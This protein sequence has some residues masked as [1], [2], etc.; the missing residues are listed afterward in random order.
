MEAL[1]RLPRITRN[2]AHWAARLA[3]VNSLI[4]KSEWRRR[5][6]LILC[7]HGVSIDDE[8]LWS[9]LYVSPEHLDRRLRAV[10]KAGGAILPFREAVQRLYAG[11]LPDCATALTFDDGAFD[12]SSRAVPVLNAVGAHSTLYLTTWYSGR[13]MPVFDTMASYLLWKGA[14]QTI[15]LPGTGDRVT[16][17]AGSGS[18]ERT[19][20]HTRLLDFAESAR[21]SGDEKQALLVELSRTVKV[22][23]D[24]LMELRMLQIMRPDEVAQLD[25]TMVDVELH[26][27]RHRTPRSQEGLA[28]EIGDNQQ[29]IADFTGDPTPRRHFCYP[30][31][32]FIADYGP[33][34]KS[35]GVETATTCDPGLATADTDPYFLPRIFDTEGLTDEMFLAWVTGAGVVTSPGQIFPRSR[36]R[37]R[38]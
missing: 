33:W 2:A 30:S 25:R 38:N 18:S 16:I 24:R 15:R 8:H 6:L 34:L 35:L 22:D 13:N 12:F 7:Y 23:F 17:P 14:G 11:E 27:H 5:R 20:L 10:R 21:L 28:V 32:D 29:C 36:G 1:L 4:S 37:V 26:T 3:G 9:D 31:G 19:A